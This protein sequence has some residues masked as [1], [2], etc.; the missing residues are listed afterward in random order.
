LFDKLALAVHPSLGQ[1]VRP[2]G[3]AMYQSRSLVRQS[4]FFSLSWLRN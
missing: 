2:R 4:W 1:A 3:F